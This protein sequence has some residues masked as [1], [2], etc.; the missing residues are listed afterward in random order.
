MKSI[1]SKIFFI[2]LTSIISSS[3]IV[4]ALGIFWSNKAVRHDSIEI[5]D[6]MAQV[7]T[8]GLNAMFRDIEQSSQV[9]SRYVSENLDD[10]GIMNQED[11]FA[12]YIARLSDISYYIANCTT[13]ALCVFVRF[14][15][16]FTN[17][18]E[19]ILWRKEGGVFLQDSLTDFPIYESDFDNSWY[20]K[21]RKNGKGV[22]TKPYYD[23]EL[24]EYVV[25]YAT[26]VFKDGKFFAVVGMN[27]DFDVIA[28]LI[29]SI[30]IYDSGYA[31]LTDEDFVITYH[32]RIPS[33]TR[34]LEHTKDFHLFSKLKSNKEI[35]E[36]TY[37]EQSPKKI[38]KPE[39]FRM[40]YN[41]LI[42][43]MRLVVSVP[44]SEIDKTRN[45]LILA[46]I[47]SVLAISLLVAFWSVLMSR[48]MS[49][50]LKE[51]SDSTHKIIAGNYDLKFT[52]RSHDE[53]GELMT[54]FTLMAKSLKIQFD[55]I[56]SLAYHDSMTG[57]KNKRAFIDA[58]NEFNEKIHQNMDRSLK[59][60]V[61]VFDVNDLKK[62]NDNY[63]HKTGDLL[64]KSACNLIIKN[65]SSSETFR[66]GGDEF[67]T[68]ITGKD[69]ENRSEILTKLRSEMDYPVPEKNE[70]FEKIS[71]AAGLAV[72]DY[73]IDTSFQSVFE[74][75]DEEM[76]R[77]KI[78]MKGGIENIR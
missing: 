74:R 50:P 45:K 67:V 62:M 2:V 3:F 60:G 8:D 39:K 65:F 31:F 49:R 23:D 27:I 7:Q 43:G 54:T 24:K 6:L 14:A 57:A 32:R 18:V 22:W 15:P 37:S 21:A 1:K 66:I 52:H 48:R 17:Q 77:T 30:S 36:Y 34:I 4:G 35:Y 25:S 56:N 16:E 72:Y 13:P 38:K 41:E 12:R 68:I 76:Y 75:A 64:I 5:L 26:P 47:I 61:I 33:G 69:Y 20:Y 63:G 28:A 42:N 11:K 44:A 55:Y 70:A 58:R 19:S 29:N 40:I 59:F 78:E 53:I 9:L 73:I 10:F 46:I 51:L 71:I